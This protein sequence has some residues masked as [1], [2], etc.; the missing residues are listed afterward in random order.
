MKSGS[1]I[2]LAEFSD[3]I[4]AV[5]N[6][7]GLKPFVR[8]QLNNSDHSGWALVD[9]SFSTAEARDEFVNGLETLELIVKG[10]SLNS[11]VIPPL[12]MKGVRES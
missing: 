7:E 10:E 3:L 4:W 8:M 5:G 1:R 2:N 11:S 9:F 6:F 12:A